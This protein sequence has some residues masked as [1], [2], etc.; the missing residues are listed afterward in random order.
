MKLISYST[1]EFSNSE[2]S[3]VVYNESDGSRVIHIDQEDGMVHLVF[4]NEE[5]LKHFI[6]VISS[7]YGGRHEINN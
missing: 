7:V 5:Q 2:M 3:V 4:A 1:H 6:T